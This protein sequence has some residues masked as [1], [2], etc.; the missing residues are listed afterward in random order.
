MRSAERSRKTEGRGTPVNVLE[1]L[2]ASDPDLVAGKHQ[3]IK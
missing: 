2:T 3:P 1:V